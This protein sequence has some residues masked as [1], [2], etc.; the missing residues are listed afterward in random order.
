MPNKRKSLQ[1]QLLDM[2]ATVNHCET[3]Y[4]LAKHLDIPLQTLRNYRKDKSF[5][6]N[7]MCL[8]IAQELH[9]EPLQVMARIRLESNP[10]DRVRGLWEKYLGRLS[11]EFSLE[12]A[13]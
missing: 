13:R 8:Q 4:Q 9:M 1:N 3:D 6:N 7:T 12:D 10:S 11:L 2:V 5:M